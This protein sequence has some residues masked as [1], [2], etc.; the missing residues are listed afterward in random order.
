[1]SR[2]QTTTLLRRRQLDKQLSALAPFVQQLRQR[3]GWIKE[4]RSALGM[5]AVQLARRLKVSQP[6][7]VKLEKSEEAETISL[8]SLRKAAEAMDCSLVYA[9]VPNE[10]LEKTL[11]IQ[12]QRRAAELSGR[13]E[14]TMELEAQGRSSEDKAFERQ[15]LAEEMVRTSSRDLWEGGDEV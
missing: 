8:K 14:H 11:L 3:Q 15:Q 4:I 10:S 9:F 13:V 6:T 12:A 2:R 7:I 1:M 5:S